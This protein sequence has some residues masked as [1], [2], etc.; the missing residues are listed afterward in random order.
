MSI[1]SRLFKKQE[2]AIQPL[3]QDEILE[4]LITNYKSYNFESEDYATIIKKLNEACTNCGGTIDNIS[5]VHIG[6]D[7]IIFEC[8]NTIIKITNLN[9]G[10]NTLTE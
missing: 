5:L 10:T 6:Q 2:Q 3:T 7:A 4:I 9:Y 8:N 1:I